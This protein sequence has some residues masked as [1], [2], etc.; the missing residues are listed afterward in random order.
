MA[1]DNTTVSMAQ[2]AL[3]GVNGGATLP[4]PEAKPAGTG[5]GSVQESKLRS[6]IGAAYD[7]ARQT[8]TRLSHGFSLGPLGMFDPNAKNPIF[9]TTDRQQPQVGAMSA[10]GL[11]AEFLAQQAIMKQQNQ[12]LGGVAARPQNAS[13]APEIDLR[14]LNERMTTIRPIG[15]GA[16]IPH[17]DYNGVMV[18]LPDGVD[19]NDANAV[20]AAMAEQNALI[21]MMNG[22][23]DEED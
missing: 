7:V 2:Q 6:Q 18:A 8:V 15:G 14:Q 5:T 11:L 23:N 16:E 3:T 17:Y 13:A 21:D 9:T 1:D 20:G 4:T 10:S 19:A 12:Q 22:I